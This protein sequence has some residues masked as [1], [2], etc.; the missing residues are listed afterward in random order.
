[1]QSPELVKLSLNNQPAHQPAHLPTIT[2]RNALG[3]AAAWL[4]ALAW[5]AAWA[6]SPQPLD[7]VWQDAARSRSLPVRL[8][9]PAAPAPAPGG[10]WPVIVYSHGLGGSAAGGGVWGQ[11]WADAGFVVVHVQHPGSDVDAVRAAPRTGLGRVS[12]ADVANAAQLLAR[13]Q[14]V[15][16][17]LNEIARQKTLSKQW[18]NVRADG[19]GVAGHS[20]GAHT[21]LGVGGQR[22]PGHAGHAGLQDPRIAALIALSPNIP[23][24]GSPTFAF[25][26]I[27]LPTLCVTGTLD[28][29]LLGNGATPQRR[30]AV[31][32]ALPAG[33]KAMLLVKD[34]DHFTFGGAQ[35]GSGS[36]RLDQQREPTAR[37]LQAQHQA[38][39]AAIT[40]NWW[41]AHLRGDGAAHAYLAS[42]SGLG[43]LDT[44]RT[45]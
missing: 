10:S 43:P 5:P 18:A 44:W 42:P 9:W 45:G 12:L 37:Q 16:F 15:V 6:Q 22:Y 7:A 23:A 30:A 34:A 31:F 28:G 1:M 36:A 17:V 33:R 39:V 32:T 35:N 38:L 14:D 8:R 26:G 13:L 11:A 21:A 25:A 41:Q 29:D 19:V 3:N 2:R 24:T 40:T 4:G 20:F 27:K